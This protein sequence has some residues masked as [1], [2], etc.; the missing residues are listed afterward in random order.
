MNVSTKLPSMTPSK[1]KKKGE[2]MFGLWYGKT[3]VSK[4]K[5]ESA[6]REKGYKLYNHS[7]YVGPLHKGPQT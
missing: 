7:F 5:L 2:K 6:A 3:L 4:H 1:P